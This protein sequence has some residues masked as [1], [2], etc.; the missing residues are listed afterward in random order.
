MLPTYV[1]MA[2]YLVYY[3]LIGYHQNTLPKSI[4]KMLVELHLSCPF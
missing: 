1:N 2:Y 3:Y 4:I